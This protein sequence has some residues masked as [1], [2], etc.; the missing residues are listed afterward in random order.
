M[1]FELRRLR[2]GELD[3]E[4]IWLAVTITSALLLAAWLRLG[5][6]IPQC[7]FHA[8]FG[9]PC[10]TCGSTRAALAFLHGDLSGAW[11]FNPLATVSFFAIA[12]YDAYALLVLVRQTARLRI[13][14]SPAARWRFTALVSSAVLLNWV[15]LLRHL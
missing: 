5:M 11:R 6:P 7:T 3:H 13:I 1:R 2:A 4:L 14:W 8:L 10:L 12:L 9:I 15:Y